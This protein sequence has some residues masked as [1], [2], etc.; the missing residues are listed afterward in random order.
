VLRYG[1]FYGPGT[2]STENMVRLVRRR[3]L[4]VVRGDRGQLPIIHIDDAVGATL[5]ALDHGIAGG[6]Y[7]VV[8]DRA[9]SMTEIVETIARYTGSSSPFRVPG[10]LPRLLAPYMARVTSVRMPLSNQRAKVELGW[11]PRYATMKEGLAAMLRPA[12][13]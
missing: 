8:D 13:S 9:V 4:P 7:D 12:A 5:A 6:V 11:R 2:P 10:W 3:R 1:L